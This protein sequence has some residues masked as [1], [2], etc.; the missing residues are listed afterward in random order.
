MTISS[1]ASEYGRSNFSNIGWFEWLDTISFKVY[2]CTIISQV[3]VST[4]LS[5]SQ[6]LLGVRFGAE[7]HFG[8]KSIYCV[9]SVVGL[10]FG[11]RLPTHLSG[12]CAGSFSN[13]H[14]PQCT[15]LGTVLHVV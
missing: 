12:R 11:L 1:Q 2:F 5:K 6:Y 3:S 9:T 15:K 13:K 14:S 7:L 10:R 8:N 4:H